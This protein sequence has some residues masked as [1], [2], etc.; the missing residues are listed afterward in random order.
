MSTDASCGSD[1][2]STSGVA[3]TFSNTN[4]KDHMPNGVSNHIG[5]DQSTNSMKVDVSS[6]E[7]ASG[8]RSSISVDE[9]DADNAIGVDS[10]D[11]KGRK[12]LSE[13]A[14]Q[15]CTLLNS[16]SHHR[17]D[18]CGSPRHVRLPTLSNLESD[19]SKTLPEASSD[20]CFYCN[21]AKGCESCCGAGNIK[22]N[23]RNSKPQTA[24]SAD[25]SNDFGKR[26]SPKDSSMLTK[27]DSFPPPGNEVEWTCSVCTFQC[28]PHW[29]TEC[30]V[31]RKSKINPKK[32][33]TEQNRV[34]PPSPID[35]NKD[36][37]TYVHRPNKDSLIQH[38][39][40]NATT[41]W[42]CRKCTFKNTAENGWKCA[43]CDELHPQPDVQIWQCVTCTLHNTLGDLVCKACKTAKN[44]IL[45][46]RAPKETV[47]AA[48]AA[49]TSKKHSVSDN[50]EVFTDGELPS[51]FE[52]HRQESS[53]IEEIRII[54]EREANDLCQQIIHHCKANKEPFVDDQFPPAQ[55][56]LFRNPDT[57]FIE[58]SIQW[59][60]PHEIVTNLFE[61]RRLPWVVYRTPMPEDIKQ[62]ILG[63]CWFLS[64]LA[65][66]AERRELVEH[67]VLTNK[68]CPEGV[69]QVRLCK[70]GL[71]RT[72]LID[73]LL[74]CHPNRTLVFSKAMRKQLWVPLI[75]K[76]MAKLAGC[77]KASEAG[78]CIEGLSVLTGAPCESISLQKNGSREED[79]F[80]DLIW[81]KLLS[82]RDQKFLMGA[83]CGGGNMVTDD[84]E[85]HK[86]GLRTKHAYSILDVQ[87]LE[88]NKLIQLRNPWGCFSWKGNWS[89]ES[90]SWETVSADGRQKLMAMGEEQ[91]IFWMDFSDLM[92]YFDCVDVCKVRPDWQ[93][94]RIKG[95]FPRNGA[96]QPK[97][98]SLTVFTT[99]Q[100][101][102][103]LFQEGS[104]GDY[105]RYPL[106]LCIVVLH[107]SLDPD[108]VSVGK[109]VTHSQ[110][111]LR[112]FVG[113]DHMF[114]PGQ[115]ILV[116]MAFS[117][118]NDSRESAPPSYVVS[119][120]SSKK[121]MVEDNLYKGPYILA[122]TLIQLAVVKGTKEE[123][124]RG[125]NAYTLMNGWAGSIIV[126]ENLLPNSW[127]HVQCNCVNSVNIVSTRGTLEAAD[128]IPPHHRQVIMVLSHLE[129]SQAYHLSRQLIHRLTSYPCGLGEW[130]PPPFGSAF[131]YPEISRDA[132]PV[133]TPRFYV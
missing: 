73:D 36:S 123:L 47:N 31:C 43:M 1:N 111:Q 37:V 18:V 4:Q 52:F 21:K 72:V 88:G 101:E 82:S 40:Q 9:S 53:L 67:I 20:I 19:C 77:Y 71:W 87:D 133:H 124:R 58:K 92:R 96:D 5:R 121:V 49:G 114:S 78:K 61:E 90:P 55:K 107:E 130:A 75:E 83:S 7:K 25:I 85:F 89:D 13:W 126:V 12:Q 8:S 2:C 33:K 100:I 129:R 120:H 94:T 26:D 128:V 6:N 110:R 106:D 91:G 69:Y 42:D 48:A 41:Q 70:D 56:S 57:G 11:V 29:E 64:A 45:P 131:H 104:R 60:R 84:E 113:C 132:A 122:D 112:G 103:G 46:E 118:W 30:Q 51:S 102:L 15:R 3:G 116:P 97:V 28:N 16:N 27:E 125:V 99:T 35:I 38:P 50:V 81:A 24:A 10:S 54:E 59:L 105:S 32:S 65:V 22:E 109:I 62:G 86:V 95:A 80:P 117:H 93:E 98:I 66:L 23:D 34:S 17:C 68:I 108:R 74:P 63:N 76:A 14:C 39:P 79:I 127:A 115:Y 119:I 44:H